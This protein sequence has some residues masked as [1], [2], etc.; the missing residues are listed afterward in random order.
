MTVT[1]NLDQSR[2]L[3]IVIVFLNAEYLLGDEVLVAPVMEEG[4]T[5]RDIYL[6]KGT[7][8]DEADP[9]HAEHVGPKWLRG[10]G[11]DIFTLPY[12]TRL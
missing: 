3:D 12:F 9:G 5:E 6:P 4:A 7:W 1:M 11:A 10:Y 8:R 2:E